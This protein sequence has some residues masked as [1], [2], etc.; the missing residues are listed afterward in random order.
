MS[1]LRVFLDDQ[2]SA[3]LLSTSDHA[4]MASEL[5]CLPLDRREC[6]FRTAPGLP[7]RRAP[8]RFGRVRAGA[9]K[10]W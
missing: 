7:A 6:L 2:P 9:G 4:A 1:R 5:A 3:P 8:L 10:A